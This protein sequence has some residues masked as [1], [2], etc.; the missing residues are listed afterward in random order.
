MHSVHTTVDRRRATVHV[1]PNGD[2]DD[3]S[4]QADVRDAVAPRLATL[5]ATPELRVRICRVRP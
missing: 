3:A 5:A 1:V 4:L 2:V